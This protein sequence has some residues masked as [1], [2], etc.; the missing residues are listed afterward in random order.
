MFPA[1]LPLVSDPWAPHRHV[2]PVSP[3]RQNSTKINPLTSV[4]N[5]GLS[6]LSVTQSKIP[7]N[8]MKMVNVSTILLCRHKH[9]ACRLCAR[10]LLIGWC[11]KHPK[12]PLKKLN[13]LKEEELEEEEPEKE[14]LD[15][16]SKYYASLEEQEKQV[17]PIFYTPHPPQLDLVKAIK[18]KP[19]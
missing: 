6:G 11:D 12:A 14:E 4:K 15:W 9:K 13:K 3:V 10:W 16:W 18:I 2:V 17:R 8:P 1:V 19:G 5:I 7:I